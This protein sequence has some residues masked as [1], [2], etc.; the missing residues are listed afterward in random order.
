MMGKIDK[1]LVINCGNCGI[2]HQADEG[3]KKKVAVAKWKRD[4]WGEHDKFGWL[5]P[6]CNI[7]EGTYASATEQP[8]IPHPK[9][10]WRGWTCPW[11][12]RAWIVSTVCVSPVCKQ[13]GY[14]K[15]HDL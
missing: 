9:Y 12:K 7:P 14:P 4:G 5:C 3:D 13:C 1:R 10:G 8:V 2:W 11:C 15:G 6:H